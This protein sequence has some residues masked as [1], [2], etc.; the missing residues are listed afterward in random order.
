MKSKATNLKGKTVRKAK[1]VS[2]GNRI[3]SSPAVSSRIKAVGSSTTMIPL[4]NVDLEPKP[5]GAIG[6]V[7]SPS[8][9][10]GV[11][12]NVGSNSVGSSSVH[13]LPNA[14]ICDKFDGNIDSYTVP[15]LDVGGK[16]GSNSDGPVYTRSTYD[17]STDTCA[18]PSSGNS[19]IQ[20][21]SGDGELETMMLDGESRM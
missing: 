15:I 9:N 19:A 3:T 8:L 16:T 10:I 14:S 21:T 5:V 17:D 4:T 18:P 11:S 1:V 6:S 7:A 20:H 12:D 13:L 2:G